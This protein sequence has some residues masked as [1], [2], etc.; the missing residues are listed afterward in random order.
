MRCRLLAQGRTLRRSSKE[1]QVPAVKR[2]R[3]R[4]PSMVVVLEYNGA[5]RVT[6]LY[7]APLRS[8]QPRQAICRAQLPGFGPEVARQAQNLSS[9]S[10]TTRAMNVFEGSTQCGCGADSKNNLLP[11]ILN[12]RRCSLPFS[13]SVH[14]TSSTAIISSSVQ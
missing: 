7:V 3:W 8:L 9:R 2:T 12:V 5:E 6:G 11:S 4:M 1:R 13:D 14:D 10:H